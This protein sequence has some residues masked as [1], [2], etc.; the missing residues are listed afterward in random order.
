MVLLL[1]LLLL[2][3]LRRRRQVRQQQLQRRLLSLSP[4]SQRPSGLGSH[5]GA[6]PSLR[7]GPPPLQVASSCHGGLP[8]LP[9][10]HRASV[11][12]RR[13]CVSFSVNFARYAKHSRTVWALIANWQCFAYAPVRYSNALRS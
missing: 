4:R 6:L 5:R 13:V 12:G 3:L 9:R 2:M 11:N 8:W 10:Q 1:L 7:R